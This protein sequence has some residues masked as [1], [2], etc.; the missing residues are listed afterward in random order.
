MQWEDQQTRRVED[1]LADV[2]KAEAVLTAATN[3]HG[4]ATRALGKAV[5]TSALD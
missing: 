4:K 5:D 3:E 2:E 1:A